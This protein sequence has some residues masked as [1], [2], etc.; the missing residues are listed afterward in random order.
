MS[1]FKIPP[2]YV[3]RTCG[4]CGQNYRGPPDSEL[5][6]E[7]RYYRENPAEAPGYWTWRR[8]SQG[9][10]VTAKWRDRDPLP[11]AGDAV[12]V[13]RKD[14]SSSEHTL[15]EEPEFHYDMA[16]NKVLRAPVA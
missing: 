9:W 14:G 10:Q 6:T 1:T 4:D 16:G 12:T 7:C 8:S 2:R 11:Q 5:C 3:D 15:A 13:H